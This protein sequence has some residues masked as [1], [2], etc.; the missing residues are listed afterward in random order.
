MRNLNVIF[1][2]YNNPIKPN[3]DTSQTKIEN[4]FNGGIGEAKNTHLSEFKVMNP[5]CVA[6]KSFVF[7]LFEKPG[8]E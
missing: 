4:F 6:K 2:R 1:L 5:L 3:G 8:A 7:C